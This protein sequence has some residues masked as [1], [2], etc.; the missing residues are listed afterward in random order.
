MPKILSRAEARC[1]AHHEDVDAT[2]CPVKAET[3]DM[4]A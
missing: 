1:P 4:Y 2:V 3:P